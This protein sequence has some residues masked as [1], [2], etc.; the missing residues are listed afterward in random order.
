MNDSRREKKN[1]YNTQQQ[2]G[3]KGQMRKTENETKEKE[4]KKENVID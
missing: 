4:G 1:T 3:K 2:K